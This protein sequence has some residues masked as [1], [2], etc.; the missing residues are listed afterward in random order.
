MVDADPATTYTNLSK[1]TI[2]GKALIVPNDTN[3]ADSTLECNLGIVN[4]ICG[5]QAMP[6]PPGAL[7]AAQ[8]T[9]IDTWIKCGAPNN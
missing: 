8:R 5:L 1:Y 9:T 6:Q 7:G 3:P 4:P 2:N